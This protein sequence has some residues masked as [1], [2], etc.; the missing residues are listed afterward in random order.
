MNRK[1]SSPKNFSN[2]S[3]SKIHKRSKQTD[4]PMKALILF[5]VVFLIFQQLV[6][7][8]LLESKL[9]LLALGLTDIMY[10]RGQSQS[11]HNR[12]EIWCT[13]QWINMLDCELLMQLTS[14][15]TFTQFWFIFFFCWW[16]HYICCCFYSLVKFSLNYISLPDRVHIFRS[17]IEFSI[18]RAH[19]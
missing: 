8:K 4:S 15:R 7:Q 16:F 9:N 6:L 1:F 13:K 11:Y 10:V 3:Y 18:F 5:I 2:I 12:N 19:S 17:Q 14:I